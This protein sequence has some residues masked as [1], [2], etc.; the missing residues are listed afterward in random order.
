MKT[1]KWVSNNNY[2]IMKDLLEIPGYLVEAP[3]YIDDIYVQ[4]YTQTPL[5]YGMILNEVYGKVDNL[6]QYIDMIPIQSLSF[7]TNQ[8]LTI[9]DVNG[10]IAILYVVLCKNFNYNISNIIH[11][12]D[13]NDKNHHFIPKVN[14]YDI[15]DTIENIEKIHNIVVLNHF[16]GYTTLLNNTYEN[17]DKDILCSD[18]I[19]MCPIEKYNYINI[20][21]IPLIKIEDMT[22]LKSSYIERG[23]NDIDIFVDTIRNLMKHSFFIDIIYKDIVAELIDVYHFVLVG[24]SLHNQI[25]L[26]HNFLDKQWII[27]AIYNIYNNKL[28]MIAIGDKWI[29]SYESNITTQ[30]SLKYAATKALDETNIQVLKKHLNDVTVGS[31]LILVIP[32]LSDNTNDIIIKINLYMKQPIHIY[33]TKDQNE[34]IYNQRNSDGRFY[35]LSLYNDWYVVGNNKTTIIPATETLRTNI[36]LPS[37][38]LPMDNRMNEIIPNN[39]IT[40]RQLQ[41]LWSS[42]RFLND[43]AYNYYKIY[44][45]IAKVPL[46]NTE[47]ILYHLE[48][49]V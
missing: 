34:A 25:C 13:N 49:N 29:F 40:D 6:Q 16:I 8:R 37:L 7:H 19:W 46:L 15:Y 20:L 42:G 44:N 21:D 18:F 26:Q 23:I 28:P 43:W 32:F 4:N 30:L 33:K 31:D 17:I 2:D 14:Q 47:E 11:S 45:K 39:K 1:I 9:D 22:M 3:F 38:T 41:Y 35:A 12:Y 10:I 36:I 48:A 27:N 24:H 5:Y